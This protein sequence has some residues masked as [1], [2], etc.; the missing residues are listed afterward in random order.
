MPRCHLPKVDSQ[1]RA[2]FRINA[3]QAN[4]VSV[5]LQ[6]GNSLKKGDDGVWTGV[7]APLAPGFHYYSLRVDG[8][9]VA[10][11]ATDSFFGSSKMSS[12]GWGCQPRECVG[13]PVR[14]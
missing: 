14:L 4:S 2:W 3:P 8:V 5:S 6:G 1:G 13:I 9:E 10:D 7:T 12:A 11:P